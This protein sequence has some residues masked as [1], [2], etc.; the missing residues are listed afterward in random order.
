MGFVELIF[1]GIPSI[2]IMLL[3]LWAQGAQERQKKSHWMASI[4][5]QAWKS[6]HEHRDALRQSA[7]Y[8]PEQLAIWKTVQILLN[9]VI[10]ADSY[11]AQ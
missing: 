7:S 2:I 5:F 1:V 10:Y 8:D 4:A 6:I 3:Y 11:L 9:K